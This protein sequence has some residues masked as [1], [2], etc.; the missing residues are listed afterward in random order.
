MVD[1]TLKEVENN[2]IVNQ[3]RFPHVCSWSE[4]NRTFYD[5]DFQ[6]PNL[7]K[8][9][10]MCCPKCSTVSFPWKSKKIS[11]DFH[12]M[13]NRGILSFIV[14]FVILLAL[15]GVSRFVHQKIVTT[16]QN[17]HLS[18]FSQGPSPPFPRSRR[19][20]PIEGDKPLEQL[21]WDDVTVQLDGRLLP[22]SL[23]WQLW[24]LPFWGVS[25]QIWQ[26]SKLLEWV[27]LWYLK[28]IFDLWCCTIYIHGEKN[29]TH[30]SL[31]NSW[32]VNV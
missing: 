22:P 24:C 9:P 28:T 18:N 20:P 3:S 6:N 5:S 21:E 1:S 4:V 10:Q 16:L 23:L 11:K 29:K 17:H 26:I 30:F 15:I 12:K 27:G 2:L 14:I 31:E 8:H 32:D 19:P 25:K 13:E 7:T